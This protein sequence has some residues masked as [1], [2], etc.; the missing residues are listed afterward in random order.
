M[1]SSELSFLLVVF[2]L[3]LL[4]GAAVM[5][6][7]WG[8]TREPR[9]RRAVAGAIAGSI[10]LVIASAFLGLC[11]L[12]ENRSEL[13]NERCSGGTPNLPLLGIPVLFLAAFG[14]SRWHE[15]LFWA[16]GALTLAVAI[17]V[18]WELLDV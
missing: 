4:I 9:V 7:T 14:A 13:F 11:G 15:E 12:G 17:V 16:L 3:P 2:V 5:L 1:S 18:P 10:L 6:F 8:A